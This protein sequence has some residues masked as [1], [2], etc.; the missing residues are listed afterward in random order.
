MR[1]DYSATMVAIVADLKITKTLASYAVTGSFI[2][3]GIGQVFCGIIADKISPVKMI[4]YAIIGT[5]A[6]NILVSFCSDMAVITFLWCINGFCQAMIW[7]PLAR[8]VLESVGKERYANSITV[9]G[10]AATI[11]TLFVYLFVSFALEITVWRIVFRCMSLFG[12]VILSIWCYMTR[13][14]IVGKATAVKEDTSDNKY[15]VLG[16]VVLA[17]LVPIFAVIIF[18]GILR[19]GIQTWLPSLVNERFGLKA[20]SSVLSTTILPILGMVSVII[21][22]ALYL[23]LKN[24]LKT[25]SV[26]FAVAF[27]ATIPFVLGL[28]TPALLTII[29]ASVASGCMHGVNH[30][31]ISIL[32]QNFAKYGRFAAFSGIN[33]GCTYL[34]A[35]VSSIGFAALADNVGWNAV[36]TSW[37]VI[38]CLATLI[39]VFKIKSWA[40][41]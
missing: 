4:K 37:C 36:Q 21:T 23:K 24:E 40:K 28:K 19:D 2:T 13:N 6:V 14:I 35:S 9:V 38:A 18:Q 3:Y 20:S 22:N 1:L 31:L 8:F 11:G 33:G 25:V 10:L 30:I 26:V 34:G 7:A 29:F 12:I 17:G 32:P 16:L 5:I 41:F 15:S 27:A 39:C